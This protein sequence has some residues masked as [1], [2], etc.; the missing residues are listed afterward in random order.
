MFLSIKT[1]SKIIII[2]TS[3]TLI[4]SSNPFRISFFT[5]PLSQNTS[6]NSLEYLFSHNIYTQLSLGVP[7]Q[8]IN[9]LISFKSYNTWVCATENS[10]PFY[11][12]RNSTS[13]NYLNKSHVF[14]T[15]KK[16]FISGIYVKEIISTE[17][18]I[19]TMIRILINLDSNC[20]EIG[21]GEIGFNND[22]LLYNVNNNDSF[23][24]QLFENEIISSK[25]ISIF[26][27]N[28]TNGEITLGD[29][30]NNL[31]KKK[32]YFEIP[33][34]GYSIVC[35]GNFIQSFTIRSTKKNSYYPMIKES[36]SINKRMMLD[37]YTSFIKV[38]RKIFN[39]IIEVS[40]SKFISKRICILKENENKINFK[41]NY[42]YLECY[43]LIKNYDLD[44]IEISFSFRE[45]IKLNLK[46]LFIML[47]NK[48]I[49]GIVGIDGL[50]HVHIG[51]IF[52]R[53]FYIFFDKEKNSMRFYRKS[54]K[55]FDNTKNKTFS[56]IL[57]VIVGIGLLL[58]L[59]NVIFVS[60]KKPKKE[61]RINN[62]VQKMLIKKSY[63]RDDI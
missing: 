44:N 56:I 9:L 5:S 1:S 26:Y 39:E 15:S 14:S 57:I 2:I 23:L 53:E 22:D 19:N 12:T 52:L 30:D 3:L 21:N 37:F 55:K 59:G 58:C 60:C 16:K 18:N 7:S 48:Y 36:I 38:D 4:L 24:E 29:S 17:Y 6:L 8:S 20:S 45:K 11:F 50:N 40:L 63:S 54:L 25:I 49:F 51:E 62:K 61:K 31:I 42:S 47:N 32:K 33:M 43:D 28:N 46:R 27:N 13:I 10:N 41:F 34:V 35:S